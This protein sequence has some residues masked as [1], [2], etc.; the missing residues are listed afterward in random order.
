MGQTVAG[1]QSHQ[2]GVHCDLGF[3]RACCRGF[4][5]VAKMV[6]T[7]GAGSSVDATGFISSYLVLPRGA[8]CALRLGAVTSIGRGAAGLGLDGVGEKC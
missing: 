6:A 7:S 2:L 1:G 4:D 5:R 3:S 8:A